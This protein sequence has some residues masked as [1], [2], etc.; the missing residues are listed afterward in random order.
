VTDS[1][2]WL[3]A[4]GRIADVILGLIAIEAA[5]LIALKR[6]RGIG[7]SL[8]VTLV[9]VVSGALLILA[10]RGAL[11]GAPWP[12]VAMPLTLSMFAHLTF[13]VIVWRSDRSGG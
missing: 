4:S 2:A 11:M 13:L 12:V 6:W 3:F 10:V 7:P 5:L 9:T 1:L 8:P